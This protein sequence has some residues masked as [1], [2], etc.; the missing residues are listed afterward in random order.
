MTIFNHIPYRY[1]NY[2][3]LKLD[4]VLVPCHK[5]NR[6]LTVGSW[7]LFAICI[8]CLSLHIVIGVLG[9][10]T[11]TGFKVFVDLTY[12]CFT[13]FV[14]GRKCIME[15]QSEDSLSGNFFHPSKTN[16]LRACKCLLISFIIWINVFTMLV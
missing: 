9:S 16:W 5:R 15:Q 7:T 6:N 10:Q 2:A 1:S 4:S 13:F 11:L 14:F 3:L 12:A 8:L